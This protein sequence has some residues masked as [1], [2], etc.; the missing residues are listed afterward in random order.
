MKK[1]YIF[2][3]IYIVSII[4][5][6]AST[7]LMCKFDNSQSCT[8]A[9]CYE[10]DFPD[11]C[12]YE[13]TLETIM[14]ISF[15]TFFISLVALIIIVII[16]KQTIPRKIVE[17]MLIIIISSII[18]NVLW[19]QI[20]NSIH[21]RTDK[22]ILYLYPEKES[23]VE[24][25]ILNK[26]V[27]TT[28]YPKYNDSWNVLVK[29]NGDIYDSNNKYYYGL[30]WEEQDHIDF[31][32]KEGFYVKSENSIE[33]LEDKLKIL[34]LNEKESNEFIMYWLPKMESDGDNLVYFKQTDE[35][36]K[37][38]E[39][40]ITPKPNTL[41]RIRMMLKK[42]KKDPKIKEQKLIQKER[43]GFTAVEWGGTLIK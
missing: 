35:L 17:I 32:F 38:D 4:A 42:V 10:M 11:Y 18:T 33:F 40:N 13:D 15:P 16:S 34:G 26:D 29:P 1:W 37:E 41:L 28:T 20:K 8:L 14:E 27:I 3:I 39:I 31:E 25:K 9:D 30:Y 43:K 22:P 36:Q 6:L 2:L 23:N 19:T 21:T 5:I 7:N 24:V 12:K